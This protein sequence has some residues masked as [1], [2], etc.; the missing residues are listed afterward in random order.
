MDAA[1]VVQE[2]MIVARCLTGRK[3]QLL[4][5]AIRRKIPALYSQEKVKDPIVYAKF[6]HAYGEGTWL[7]T[8]FD[9]RDRFF[10]AI[11]LGH[12]WELGYFSLREMESVEASV[13]G[14]R[15]R[16]LQAIER[17]KWFRPMSLSK[18]KRA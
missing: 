10:G 3:Q 1:K 8:E 12:G 17:D 7:A 5:Q 11:S 4:T 2:L 6:F 15:V 14:K 16:G 13:N 9:G 18:A